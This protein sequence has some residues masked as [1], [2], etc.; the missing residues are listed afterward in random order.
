MADHDFVFK[1]KMNGDDWDS[2]KSLKDAVKIAEDFASTGDDVEIWKL[3]KSGT[4]HNYMEWE[5]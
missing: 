4:A 5:D 3:V 2:A 1:I